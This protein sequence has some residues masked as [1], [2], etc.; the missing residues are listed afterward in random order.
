MINDLGPLSCDT[1][2][3]IIPIDASSTVLG[4]FLRYIVGDE[5][6]FDPNIHESKYG[7]ELI[8]L[9][10]RFDCGVAKE[11]FALSLHRDE[12]P[13]WT[14]FVFASHLDDVALARVAI[15]EMDDR[16]DW[17][18]NGQWDKS[19]GTQ[20]ALPYLLGLVNVVAQRPHSTSTGPFNWSTLIPEFEPVTTL[21]QERGSMASDSVKG[22]ICMLMCI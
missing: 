7:V 10:D 22:K 2:A 18:L 8:L 12:S 4:M 11:R 20:P 5:K 9:C 3:N 19:H 13:P 17:I 1:P 16:H 14:T 21:K 6:I 15:G